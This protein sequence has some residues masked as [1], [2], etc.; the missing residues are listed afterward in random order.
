[1]EE[2][3]W[4]YVLWYYDQMDVI[5]APSQSTR[6]ELIARGLR[7]EKIRLYP[8]GIDV[9]QFHPAKRN[10]F[11]QKEYPL[12]EGV[13]LI[14]VGR[15]SKEKN[16]HLLVEAFAKVIAG[17]ASA[18]LVIVGDGPYLEELR[19]RMKDLPCCF[20]GYLRGESLAAAYASADLFVFPSAT[21]TFGNVVLEAQ[22]SGLPVIVTDHGGPCENMIA[23]KT[24]L[25]CKADDA[26]SLHEAMLMLIS[27]SAQRLQMGRTAR[28]Y[29]EKCSFEHAFLQMWEL[30][31]NPPETAT[32]CH[33]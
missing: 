18:Q 3:S 16:L 33:V 32:A 29:V 9:A 12:P 30:F 27:N 22:A 28:Q 1:M 10:G 15:V 25:I 7:P 11:F 17:G 2:L 19:G 13:K 14:Y 21:D 6:D 20:T 4:K 24:G 23:G 31:Q 26:D 5:Y 8:R